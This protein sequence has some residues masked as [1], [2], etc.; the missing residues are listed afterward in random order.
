ML[1]TSVLSAVIGQL[2]GRAP[3]ATDQHSDAWTLFNAIGV[4]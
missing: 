3:M 4:S 1:S 2:G